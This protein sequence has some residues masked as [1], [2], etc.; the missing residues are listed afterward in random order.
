MLNLSNKVLTDLEIKF[1]GKGLDFA[2]IQRKIS[3]PE[4]KQYFAD[5]CRRMRRKW[6][7]RNEPTPQ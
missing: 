4:L 5:F 2:R 7:F 6:F 1:L 3:E